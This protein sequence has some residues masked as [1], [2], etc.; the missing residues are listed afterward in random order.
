MRAYKQKTED[1]L[2]QTAEFVLPN[3]LYYRAETDTVLYNAAKTDA[4]GNFATVS[5]LLHYV[6]ALLLFK[7]ESIIFY[8]WVEMLWRS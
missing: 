2:S 4:N 5:T 8:L 7:E 3:V 1:L 6:I